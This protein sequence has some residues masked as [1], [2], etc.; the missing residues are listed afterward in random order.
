L[1]AATCVYICATTNRKIH[2]ASIK[3]LESAFYAL[4]ALNQ[5]I[6]ALSPNLPMRAVRIHHRITVSGKIDRVN[7][8]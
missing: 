6:C 3:C 4:C 5:G 8:G 1:L 7:L 2:R